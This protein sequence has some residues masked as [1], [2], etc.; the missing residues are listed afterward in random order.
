VLDLGQRELIVEQQA[1]DVDPARLFLPVR[2]GPVDLEEHAQLAL[3]A[4]VYGFLGR[5][6]GSAAAGL[7]LDHDQGVTVLGDD[8]DLADAAAPVASK[9]AK[10]LL[11]E[12]RQRGLLAGP[13]DAIAERTDRG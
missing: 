8:V 2:V 6:E 9:D 3:L 4:S 13:T 1:D 12:M 10:P 11:T 7:D 5:P